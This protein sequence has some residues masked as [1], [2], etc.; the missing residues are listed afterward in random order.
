MSQFNVPLTK[1]AQS[2]ALSMEKKGVPV[3][4]KI[5][6]S[7]LIDV[8]GSFDDEH[9]S[10]ITSKFMSRFIPWAMN[11]DPDQKMDVFTFSNTERNVQH[12]NAVTAENHE[13]FIRKNIVNKVVGYNGGTDYSYVIEA[14]MREFGFLPTL[15][16]E[17]VTEQ[18]VEKAGFFGKMLG[19]KD[20]VKTVTSTVTKSVASEQ[21]RALCVILTDGEN[22]DQARTIQVLKDSQKRGDNIYFLFVGMNNDPDVKFK[23]IIELGDM[24]T[25]TGFTRVKNLKAFAELPDDQ[26]NDQFLTDE[27]VQWIKK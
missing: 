9:K 3:I 11:F 1:S 20:E 27:F 4:P 18:K 15:T 2:F 5:E 6:M 23:N 7:F 16:Q 14:S 21:R 8:S 12:V 24:F 17:L 10:G 13:D 22:F 26:L 25:N 19:K